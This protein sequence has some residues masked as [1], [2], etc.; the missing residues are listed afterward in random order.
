MNLNEAKQAG[1]GAANR[2]AAKLKAMLTTDQVEEREAR[3]LE[4]D[5]RVLMGAALE[6]VARVEGQQEPRRG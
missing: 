5:A 1:F 2:A 3:E 6:I 4:A